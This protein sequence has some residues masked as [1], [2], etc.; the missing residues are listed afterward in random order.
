MDKNTL[1]TLGIRYIQKYNCYPAAKGWKIATAG[2]SRDEIYKIYSSWLLFIE[3]LKQHISIP[4]N[5]CDTYPN[6]KSN[7]NSERDKQCLF[8]QKLTYSRNTF[9][10]NVCFSAFKQ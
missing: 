5:S 7:K 6:G 4:D 10:S 8:C 3:E 9:C 2:C 1:I